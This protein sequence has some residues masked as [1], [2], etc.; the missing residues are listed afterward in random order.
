MVH[1][2]LL[3]VSGRISPDLQGQIQRGERPLT[4]Y[5]AL[6]RAFGADLLDYAAAEAEL[7]AWGR[8][9]VHLGGENLRLAWACFR[10][11]RR[12]RLI[13]TD[14][15]Q[16]GLPLAMLFKLAWRRPRPRHMM[17]G[18]VLSVGKKMALLDGLSLQHYIDRFVVYSSWQKTFI[19]Q[20]WSVPPDRVIQTPFMVDADFFAPGAAA[21][22][23]QALGLPDDGLPIVCSAGLEYRD[24]DTLL[25][26]VAGLDVRVVLA[27]ASPWS[28][29]RVEISHNHLPA[30]VIV[31]SFTQFEL[32]QLYALCAF[33]VLPLH[34]VAFQAGVTT[35]LEAMAMGK[36][37]ICTRTP[38]Q[39]DVVVVG[40]TGLY[41]EP[42]DA[43]SLRAAVLSLLADPARAAALGRQGRQRVLD[44]MS[45][46]CYADRLNFYVQSACAF[47]LAPYRTARAGKAATPSG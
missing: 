7:G 8:L 28:K 17:I 31:R 39:T 15:E 24:Y 32:R 3:T 6:A 19:E 27:A 46:D 34:P 9:L 5:V 41:V 40:E 38:G 29:R 22:S 23:C 35:L 16:V 33:V 11:S 37:V 45:L 20:R 18:H 13:F 47:S 12:Y 43:A 44:Q 2:I 14:G 21:V 42:H 4:D 36:A 26:A 10:H 25:E 1:D 30:N